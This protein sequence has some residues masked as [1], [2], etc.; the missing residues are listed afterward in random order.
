[1]WIL[2]LTN[3]ESVL[4]E[5]AFKKKIEI[6]N[7]N[8]KIKLKNNSNI[9]QACTHPGWLN[10]VL[11]CLIFVVWNLLHVTLLAP[12]N[13]MRL[14]GVWKVSVSVVYV[15]RNLCIREVG[16][17]CCLEIH[18]LLYA[19]MK[20]YIWTLNYTLYT[21]LYY[22]IYSIVLCCV[23]CMIALSWC[24]AV[25]MVWVDRLGN[26]NFCLTGE[27]TCVNIYSCLELVQSRVILRSDQ[28]YH[29]SKKSTVVMVHK[30]GTTKALFVA[31]R[32]I[33]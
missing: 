19:D 4:R 7:D 10:F 22:V 16:C 26:M 14:L 11:W 29:L 32:S 1:M 17:R 9:N 23:F 30:Y 25:G 21:Y 31:W 12:G 6:K 2:E 15:T 3:R 18:T 8:T 27:L 13:M 24:R 5:Y 20:H 28:C 33:L